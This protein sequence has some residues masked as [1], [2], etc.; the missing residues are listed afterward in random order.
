MDHSRIC[1]PSG[2]ML[3]SVVGP[4][5]KSLDLVKQNEKLKEMKEE[6][7]RKANKIEISMSELSICTSSGKIKDI[8][9]EYDRGKIEELYNKI[10]SLKKEK[11]TTLDNMLTEWQALFK[12]RLE[13]VVQERVICRRA[14]DHS[15]ANAMLSTEQTLSI[16]KERH[17]KIRE[18]KEYIKSNKID[19]FKKNVL[20]V[21]LYS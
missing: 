11:K 13:N 15:M 6:V 12:G 3:K 4:S 1:R 14:L 20:M 8:E 2:D 7:K 9:E 21:K 16:H 19:E 10:V 18:I 17:K 5:K